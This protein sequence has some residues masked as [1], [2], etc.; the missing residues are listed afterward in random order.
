MVQ[1]FR[2]GKL[3][4]CSCNWQR[5]NIGYLSCHSLNCYSELVPITLYAK[6]V[7]LSKWYLHC[8]IDRSSLLYKHVWFA[9]IEYLGWVVITKEHFTMSAQHIY[10]TKL[11]TIE[12]CLSYRQRIEICLC[13]FHF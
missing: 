11:S 13:F 6:V 12:L 8:H 1:K 7:F 10:A 9:A 4:S 5:N 3:H 2:L